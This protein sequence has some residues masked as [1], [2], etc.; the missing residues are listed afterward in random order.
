MNTS[1]QDA[2]EQIAHDPK[3]PDPWLALYLDQSYPMEAA[4]K[5]DLLA[6]MRSRSRQFLLPVVRPLARASMISIQLIKIFI[7]GRLSASRILHWSIARGLRWFVRPDANRIVLRHF[8]IGSEVL[9]FIARNVPGMAMQLDPLRPRT[10]ED[11]E[12][13]VFLRHDLNLFN[14][15]IRLNQILRERT[16]PLELPPVAELDFSGISEDFDLAPMPDRWLNLVDVQTAVEI[17]TPL[18]QLFLTDSDFWRATNSL[19]LDETIGI[20][21]A[22]L[23]RSP[24][25]LGLVNNKHPMV[26]MMTLGAGFRLMLHGLASEGLHSL[27]L[28]YKRAQARGELD[29]MLEGTGALHPFLTR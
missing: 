20:Y 8:H 12:D 10:L 6:S 27:L 17:Y 7:P 14:F 23:L 21:V 15:V 26:P 24:S 5:A 11:L 2:F 4:A 16:T 18:Y 13:D 29:H 28:R 25:H 22:A 1:S 19:Q 9:D 3:D